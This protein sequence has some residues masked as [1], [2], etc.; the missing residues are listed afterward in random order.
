MQAS[1]STVSLLSGSTRVR[2]V[3]QGL[4]GTLLTMEFHARG[5]PVILQD[6]WMPGAATVVAPGIV[7][8]MAGRK[9]RPPARI[10]ALLDNLEAAFTRVH[11]LT[12]ESFWKPC[13]ILR[14]FSEPT[15]LDT[16]ALRLQQPEVKPFVES[17]YPENH[18]PYLNDVFGS[19]LTLKG[20]WA[21]LPAF[22]EV[23][24]AWF[25][26]QGMLDETP[27]EGGQRTVDEVVIF[28]NGWRLSEM[29]EWAFVPHNPAKGE[30]LIVRFT[31]PLPRDRIYNQGCWL[32][33][34]HGDVWRVGATYTWSDFNSEPSVDGAS[35]LQERLHLLTPR[36][37]KVE[38]QV[39]GVRPIVDDTKPLLGKH[40]S[41]PN[42]WVC[43][44]MG[45]KGVLHAPT[46]AIWLVDHMLEGKALLPEWNVNR[47]L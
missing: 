19:F 33:P 20:G 28:C 21:D 10:Q 43:N 32:Q 3:G 16:F 27:W 31:D 4:T 34:I 24:R 40:P 6:V 18:F 35:D 8:P 47:F 2:I 38:D 5:V 7:N 46:A 26:G 42:W 13:P 1:A 9:F 17:Q 15:Q 14:M 45:S 11:A 22:L 39:A 41:I 12:G 44:A 30:M 36:D 37:F 23:T 29:S 25:S